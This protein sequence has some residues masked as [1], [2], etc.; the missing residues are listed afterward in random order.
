MGINTGM[1]KKDFQIVVFVASWCPHCQG[2]KQEVWTKESVLEAAKAFHDSKPA[3]NQVD[4]PG[5][6]FLNQQFE[7]EAYPTVVIMNE[8]R[9]VFKR[10]HNMDMEETIKFLEEFDGNKQV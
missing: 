10:A 7:I 9:E 3:I 5:Y 2:M 1:D 8:D 4:A 6:E